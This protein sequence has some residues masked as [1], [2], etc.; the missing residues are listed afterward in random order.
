MNNHI[1]TIRENKCFKQ[2]WEL[3]NNTFLTNQIF[4]DQV[5]NQKFNNFLFE[6]FDWMMSFEFWNVAVKPLAHA[7]QDEYVLIGILDPDP[8]NYFYHEFG[9]YNWFKLPVNNLTEGDFW[10]ILVTGPERSPADAMRYNSET[11]IWLPMSAKWAIWGE[12]SVELCALA[13]SDNNTQ[14]VE[15]LKNFTD[16]FLLNYSNKY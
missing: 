16:R 1:V 2:L 11:I 7:S 9:Y 12:R 4:P 13:F 8:I 6:E 3:V 15:A 14:I 10:K 5:F